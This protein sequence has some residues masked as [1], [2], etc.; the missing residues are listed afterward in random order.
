MTRRR[1]HDRNRRGGI[2]VLAAFL[3][4]ALV[5]MLAFAID[6]GY[7]ANS[8]AELQRSADAAA[9]AGCY[10]LIYQGTPGTLV[11]LSTNIPK[12]PTVAGQYAAANQVCKSAP[13]LAN[14]DIV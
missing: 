2:T 5:A 9:L 12:V 4:I 10:Q 11:D 3:M 1:I 8:Q 13:S 6:L 14:S 7:L